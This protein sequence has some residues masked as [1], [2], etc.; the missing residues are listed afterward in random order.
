MSLVDTL[1]QC[2]AELGLRQS[3]DEVRAYLEEDRGRPAVLQLDAA[4]KQQ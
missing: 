3:A 2:A 4:A 1:V